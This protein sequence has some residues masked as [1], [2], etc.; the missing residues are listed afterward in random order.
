VIG[1][2]VDI[3]TGACIM[4]DVRVGSD[5]FVCA[6]SLVLTNVAPHS[7]VL[8]VPARHLPGRR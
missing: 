3:G 2:R 4:G 7:S 8:G 6:N 5:S 1:D